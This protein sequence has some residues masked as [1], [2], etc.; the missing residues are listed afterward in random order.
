MINYILDIVLTIVLLL[1]A[2]ILLLKNQYKARVKASKDIDDFTGLVIP[3]E[4]SKLID[5]INPSVLIRISDAEN[6]IPQAAFWGKQPPCIILP[7]QFFDKTQKDVL[8][9]ESNHLAAIVAHELGHIESKKRFYR[10]QALLM[11]GFGIAFCFAFIFPFLS[12]W[13]GFFI[14]LLSAVTFYYLINSSSR[15]NEYRADAFAVRCAQIPLDDFAAAL[16][17]SQKYSDSKKKARKGLMQKIIIKLGE[18]FVNTH[19]PVNQ[20]IQK[21]QKFSCRLLCEKN[22]SNEGS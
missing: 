5:K 22:N 9:V 7:K 6:T 1:V 12:N 17:F 2:S 13:I 21:L 15:A 18:I 11:S 8:Q 20:R 19:P 16:K 4:I 14:S 10:S 3:H